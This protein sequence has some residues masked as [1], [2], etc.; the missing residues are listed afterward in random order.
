MRYAVH[1]KFGDES[2]FGDVHRATCLDTGREVAIKFLR[3]V[4]N[5]DARRRFE[6]EVRLLE[7]LRH[8]GIIP[9]LGFSLDA[10][11]PFYVMEFMRGG[12][13]LN[14]AGQLSFETIRSI[15]RRL[16]GVLAFLHGRGAIHRDLK[17]DNLLVDDVGDT[18]LADFGLGNDPRC[19]VLFT[20][21]AG[22][23]YGYVAPELYGGAPA[24][25]ASDCYSLGATLFHLLTG[26]HPR[27][28]TKL[29]PWVYRA[30]VP[31]DLRAVVLELVHQD[32]WQRPTAS[33]LL[34]RTRHL[35]EHKVPPLPS[36]N[37]W[38]GL[39]QLAVGGLLVVGVVALAGRIFRR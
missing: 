16:A 29:D 5:A 24:T 9:L 17:P 18:T 22:G 3:D 36:R 25:A 32:P 26:V 23:T 10:P 39:L 4:N 35:P 15:A 33:S 20:A 21:S 2:G 12:T 14:R 27:S 7:Q 13:L 28:A 31:A 11:R 6:R 37:V 8:D 34:V 1:E 30:D 38:A 19:T